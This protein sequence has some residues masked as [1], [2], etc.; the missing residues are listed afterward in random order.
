MHPKGRYGATHAQQISKR[1][2]TVVK[3]AAYLK[4]EM[5]RRLAHAGKGVP[6]CR[7]KAAKQVL[8]TN[9]GSRL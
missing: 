6:R 8:S 3:K 9:T 1:N 5:R 4:E 2:S 7:E